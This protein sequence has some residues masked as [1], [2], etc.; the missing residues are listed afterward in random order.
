MGIRGPQHTTLARVETR[1]TG[2][3]G[4]ECG[5][6]SSTSAPDPISNPIDPRFEQLL[7]SWNTLPEHIKQSIQALVTSSIQGGRS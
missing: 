2:S 4:A 6:L 7:R 5:A 1:I 3:G